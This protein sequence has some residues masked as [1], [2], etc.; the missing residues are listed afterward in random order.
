MNKLNNIKTGSKVIV[1]A[2][3][4]KGFITTVNR[5]F[6]DNYCYLEDIFRN[7]NL[8]TKSTEGASTK[9]VFTKIHI[10]NIK[11]YQN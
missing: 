9:K 4:K 1:I 5:K 11:L 8:K 10:S 2:G 3:N 6:K 7:K